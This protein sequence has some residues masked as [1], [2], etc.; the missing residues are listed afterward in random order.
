[1]GSFH[2]LIEMLIAIHAKANV[3]SRRAREKS[4]RDLHFT[5]AKRFVGGFGLVE[6]PAAELN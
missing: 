1:L 2:Q 5:M 4:L 3:D 6:D